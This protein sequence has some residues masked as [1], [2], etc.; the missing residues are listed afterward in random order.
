MRDNDN[1]ILQKFS[2]LAEAPQIHFK[3]QTDEGTYHFTD[4]FHSNCNIAQW[5][6]PLKAFE[7]S[8][9]LT[10]ALENV[11]DQQS[12]VLERVNRKQR[13]SY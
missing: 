11:Y 13:A 6:Q 9:Q 8:K 5:L 12:E 2:N 7:K 1:K 4:A 10:V 3:H